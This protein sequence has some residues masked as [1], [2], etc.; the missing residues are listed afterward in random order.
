MDSPIDLDKASKLLEKASSQCDYA[1]LRINTTPFTSIRIK[2]DETEITASTKF[3]LGCRVLKN[4]SWGFA[5]S[6]KPDVESL[7][8]SAL[9]LASLGK[10][11]NKLHTSIPLQKTF[12]QKAKKPPAEI[13]LEEKVSRFLELRN[14]M[15]KQSPKI[16]N[17]SLRYSDSSREKVFLSSEGARLITKDS[18]IIAYFMAIAK[19]NGRL[20]EGRKSIGGRGGFEFLQNLEHRAEEACSMSL[21]LLKASSPPKGFFP[22]VVDSEMAGVMAHE[23]VGH[24]SEADAI[25][26][27]D[28]IL[29]GK[30]GKKI[31]AEI[32]N[33]TD[34][35]GVPGGFGSFEF[36]D[37]G[38]KSSATKIVTNGIFTGF[39]QSRETA[40]L[41]RGEPN[42]SA[43][44]ASYA[45]TPI[46]RM[47]NT[48]FLPGEQQKE[49]LF[50]G[51]KKGVYV[52]GMQG[53]CVIT[54]TGNFVF[55]SQ[56]GFMIENGKITTP[57]RN[58]MLN[59]DILETLKRVEGV[60]KDFATSPGWCGKMGQTINVSDGGPHVRIG[61][62]LIS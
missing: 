9:R 55:T 38:T 21:R 14:F 17:V 56:E 24:A 54:K 2:D 33:I 26:S 46:V 11:K 37:E 28:T 12:E 22:T 59:G 3:G 8:N 34:D 39:M 5:S 36:D 7:L 20:E 15:R 10:G 48:F 40:A 6:E 31:G 4:G 62:I 41:L 16:K 53:G 44:A 51:I 32:V 29:K 57:L 52:K 27:N 47:S 50:E 49:E 30:L 25:M 58:C 61:K 43:R 23:A 19:E 1:D 13:S 60:S 35:P 45:D 18:L 42:G